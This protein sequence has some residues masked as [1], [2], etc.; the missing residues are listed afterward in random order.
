MVGTKARTKARIK[1]G[2]EA[3]TKARPK[4]EMEAGTTEGYHEPCLLSQ[5]CLQLNLHRCPPSFREFTQD[6]FL[7]GDEGASFP[8][9]SPNRYRSFYIQTD[10]QTALPLYCS[11]QPANNCGESNVEV[12]VTSR[13]PKQQ[14]N[15]AT[16]HQDVRYFWEDFCLTGSMNVTKRDYALVSHPF[17]EGHSGR[18]RVEALGSIYG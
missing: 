13:P 7:R 6:H 12:H 4:A 16:K 18:G 2:M 10:R 17:R 5:R 9:V 8:V 14:R 3:R 15:E 11:Q 1:A